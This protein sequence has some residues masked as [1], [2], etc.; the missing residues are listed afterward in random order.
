ML[1]IFETILFLFF[2]LFLPLPS[3]MIETSVATPLPTPNILTAT[4]SS[5]F[6]TQV[7]DGDTFKIASGESTLT[8]RIIGVNT[9]ETKDPR[10]DVECFGKEASAQLVSHIHE[11]TVLLTSDPSQADQDRYGRLLRYVYLEDGADVGEKLIRNGY[12]Y[13]YTYNS[14]YLKQE[15]YK[16]AQ[17]EAE[18]TQKGLWAPNACP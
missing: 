13:E 14:P 15:I 18:E 11:K 16:D 3:E 2:S 8:V 17:T 10:K 1:E 7:V 6:V 12:A 9:P 4:S 5:H